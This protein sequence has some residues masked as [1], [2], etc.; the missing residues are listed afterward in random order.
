M[1]KN[2]SKSKK[3][4]TGTA[5]ATRSEIRHG[6]LADPSRVEQEEDEGRQIGADHVDQGD[7]NQA[8]DGD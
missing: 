8:R 3:I 1:S 4:P 2:F 6:L 5:T 7:H